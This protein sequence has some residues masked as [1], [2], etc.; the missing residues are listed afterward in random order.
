MQGAGWGRVWSAERN[1]SMLVSKGKARTWKVPQEKGQKQL[2]NEA[3]G[4]QPGVFY[5]VLFMLG[6]SLHV[7]CPQRESVCPGLQFE[8]FVFI[9]FLPESPLSF[10][11]TQ[12]LCVLLRSWVPLTRKGLARWKTEEVV[13]DFLALASSKSVHDEAAHGC[14]CLFFLEYQIRL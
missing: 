10:L 7:H 4:C 1:F 2:T 13:P 11:S 8:I 6:F 9:Y 14:C 5:V 12:L 3:L